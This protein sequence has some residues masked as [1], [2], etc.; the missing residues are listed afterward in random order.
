MSDHAFIVVFAIAAYA[1]F[2][3]FITV[4]IYLQLKVRRLLSNSLKAKG[5]IVSLEQ[6][7]CMSSELL[8]KVANPVFVFKDAHGKEHSVRS[9]AGE[10]P[11]VHSVG[12]HVDVIYRPES[13][14]EATI[15]LKT[16][17]LMP[18]ICFLAASIA[19]IFAT[20]IL[21]CLS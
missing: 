21:I 5:T 18:R 14:Q 10:P 9:T 20:V 17:I 12:N 1:I 4:G 6:S 19:F 7:V 13:P 11:G 8:Y 16:S 3:I 2:A 15:N